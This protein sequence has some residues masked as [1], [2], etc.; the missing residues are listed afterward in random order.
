MAHGVEGKVGTEAREHE[1]E[2]CSLAAD[3]GAYSLHCFW[4]E[5][6]GCID[7]E[8]GTEGRELDVQG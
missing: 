1:A 5:E 8:V 2:G 7:G 6:R 4:V 3:L